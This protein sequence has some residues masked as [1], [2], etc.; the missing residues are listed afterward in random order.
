LKANKDTKNGHPHHPTRLS[1]DVE[2][3]EFETDE[4]VI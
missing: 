2:L 1:Y 4:Y 3:I